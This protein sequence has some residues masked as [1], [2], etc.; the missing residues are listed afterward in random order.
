MLAPQIRVGEQTIGLRWYHNQAQICQGLHFALEMSNQRGYE[1]VP[2]LWQLPGVHPASKMQV[3]AQYSHGQS[4]IPPEQRSLQ[5]QLGLIADIQD[6]CLALNMY[7]P[8][9]E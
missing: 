1:F 2:A 5:G 6:A 3:V 7:F 9:D 4:G 8:T